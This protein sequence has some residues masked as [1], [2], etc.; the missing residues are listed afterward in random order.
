MDGALRM[1][2]DVVGGTPAPIIPRN[3]IRMKCRGEYPVWLEGA[4]KLPRPNA[5][6][7]QRME[8]QFQRR[9]YQCQQ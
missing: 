8:R 7:G 2:D 9:Q 1:V 5:Q 4:A 3:S 6:S